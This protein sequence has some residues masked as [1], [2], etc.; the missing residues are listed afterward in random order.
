[1]KR[2]LFF[3]IIGFLFVPLLQ[4]KYLVFHE[5]ELGG[6]FVLAE[7]P[8]F[9]QNDWFNANFQL[10]YDEYTNDHIGFRGFLVKTYNQIHF[11]FF[12]KVSKKV[13]VL[14]AD[15]I[16]FDERYI[17]TTLGHDYLGSNRIRQKVEEIERLKK[18]LSNEGK[19]L[20]VVFAPNKAR[21]YNEAIPERFKVR[22]TT[23][24]E[25][26]LKAF[27]NSTVDF[28][29]FNSWFI[30]KKGGY[31]LVP[32]YGIHWSNYGSFLATDSLIRF[33]N[34]SYGY[35]LPKYR[36]DSLILAKE[37]IKPDYDIG[38]A[39]NLWAFLDDEKYVYPSYE[40]VADD[41]S[42]KKNLMIIS[43]S[44]FD[45]IYR[46]PFCSQVFNVTGYYY[47]NREIRGQENRLKTP[48]DLILSL[49]KT[50][51]VMLM[52]TEWN[53]YRLGF[54][55]VEEMNAYYSGEATVDPT[56]LN[57]IERIRSDKEW[58]S[59]VVKSAKERGVSVDDMLMIS[60]K[61]V[62]KKKDS[63]AEQ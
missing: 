24:Y 50:D 53:L 10:C 45:Q 40:V 34:S 52:M 8:S 2:I 32:K 19:Q 4:G 23:N 20:L 38:R 47:Y 7:E 31:N 5:E 35:S 60:A 44:F 51:L 61:Y 26:F 41:T 11:S 22:D 54:G 28:I 33:C 9:N 37:P 3:T 55:V 39:T 25:V 59:S 42:S 1:M 18:N 15:D 30:E 63:T 17:E 16:L 13:G 48:N 49:P 56:L 21:Y 43:D 6:A 27:K 14:G 46:S 57:L 58:Y 62:R 12:N 29:D 36:L